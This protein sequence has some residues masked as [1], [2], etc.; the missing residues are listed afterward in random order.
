ME[1]GNVHFHREGVYEPDGGETEN[2]RQVDHDLTHSVGV[3][4]MHVHVVEPHDPDTKQ[5]PSVRER[6]C[7]QINGSGNLLES[8]EAEHQKGNDVTNKTDGNYNRKYVAVSVL[9]EDQKPTLYGIGW[10]RVGGVR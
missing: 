1:N 7:R 8:S 2:K 5:E 9:D 4:E 10:E 3:E 6:K